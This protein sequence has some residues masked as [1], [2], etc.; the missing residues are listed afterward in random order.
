M[1]RAETADTEEEADRWYSDKSVRR[2]PDLL[3]RDEVARA[4]NT[5]IKEGRGSPHGGVYLDIATRRDADYITRRLPGM[6]HQF[7]EL[8]DVDITREPMEVGPTCH[9]MMGGV[10]VDAETQASTVPG[11]FA[12]GEVAGG[13]ARRQP[14]R[15]QLAVGSA[16]VRPARRPARR[17]IRVGGERSSERRH[18]RAGGTRRGR[19]APVRGGRA[20]RTRTR[21]SRTCRSACSPSSASS[22]PRT[23]WPR[24]WTSWPCCGNGRVGCGSRGTGSTTPAGTW[25]STS[26]RCWP[27]RSASPGPRA[28]ARR[29][30]ARQTRDDY[31]VPTPSWRKVNVVVRQRDGELSLSHEPLP[32]MPRGARRPV[33]EG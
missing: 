15:R 32:A 1:F 6:Y 10:R 23:S 16:G 31:P 24:R 33:K 7:R 25:R 19:A 9:Y 20:P 5:E 18:R 13:H 26:T 3:P 11:L 4:I 29:A 8:A 22:A 12:A 14:P 17:R 30:A 28:S 2:T 27:C 21:S